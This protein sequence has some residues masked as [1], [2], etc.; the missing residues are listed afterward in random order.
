M[1]IEVIARRGTA[2]GGRFHAFDDAVETGASNRAPIGPRQFN[3]EEG[4]GQRKPLLKSAFGSWIQ[5]TDFVPKRPLNAAKDQSFSSSDS[6]S[7][8]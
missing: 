6:I 8:M 1:P 4:D 3:L 7:P 2:A 5:F